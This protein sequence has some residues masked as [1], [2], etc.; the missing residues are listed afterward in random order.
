MLSCFLSLCFYVS[1]FNSFCSVN[2]QTLSES[3]VS[4]VFKSTGNS[5]A[6][7][8]PHQSK[9]TSVSQQEKDRMVLAQIILYPF[10]LFF[11]TFGNVMTIVIHKRAALTSSLSVFFIVLAV[12]DLMLLY[13]NCFK[14]WLSFVF[15]FNLSRQNNVLCK[16][17]IFTLYVSGVLSA[18]TL[19]AMTA[20]RAVCVLWPHRANLLCTVRRSKVI[21]VSMVL[22]IAAIHSHL[23]YG[24]HV[25][26]DSGRRRCVMIDEYQPFY[27]EIWLWVDV[28]IFSLLP[29]MCLA[30]SNSLLVWKLNVSVREA[31]VSLGSGQADM[32]NA[33]KQ[34]AT[35]VTVTLMAVSAAFLVFTFPISFIQIY[36]FLQWMKGSLTNLDSSQAIYYTWQISYPLWYANSCINFYIYCLTGSRFRTEAKQILSCMFPAAVEKP[37]GNATVRTS[38]SNSSK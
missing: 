23:L 26:T 18:W 4:T 25:E 14:A 7:I 34:K 38:S 10:L 27:H 17:F 24:F 16:L 6:E 35:S 15:S 29:W 8:S 13:S 9:G 11:G 3:T 36:D 2:G 33:R 20:Q 30:V 21:V 31:A 32:M 1:A 19:V 5:T 22:F 28:L 12:A 37:E